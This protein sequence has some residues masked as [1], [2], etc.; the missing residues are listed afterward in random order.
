MYLTYTSRMMEFRREG[1]EEGISIGL[2]R[3]VHQKALETAR[4]LLARG[5]FS[6][7]NCR[8]AE[9]FRFSGTGTKKLLNKSPRDCLK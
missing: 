1:L 2:E 8:F 5:G 3:G 6:C 7:G 4:K 9:S